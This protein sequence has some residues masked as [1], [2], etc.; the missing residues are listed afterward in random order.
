M[1]EQIAIVDR[2]RGPQ[3]SNS[4]ITVQDILPYWRRGASNDEIREL[5]P[6]L[7]DE[8][9]AILNEY[10]RDNEEEVLRAES[11]IKAYHDRMR[12]AQPEWTRRNDHLS[13]EERYALL[14]EKLRTQTTPITP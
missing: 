14:K 12:A 3:L 1:Q 4:R 7:N 2:G 5:M 11:R 6:S 9:I 10:I 13:A 8:Q